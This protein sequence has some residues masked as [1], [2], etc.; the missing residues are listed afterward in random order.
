MKL[1]RKQLL[2]AAILCLTLRAPTPAAEGVKPRALE[3]WVRTELYFATSRAA[4]EVTA[5]D[6]AGFV[7]HHVT[8]LF[9]DGMTVLSG[10]GQFRKASGQL[11]KERSYLLIL[12][13]PAQLKDAN[14]RIQEL[15]SIYKDTF[16]QE[17]VLR[18]DSFALVSF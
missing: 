15:R 11:V 10:Y 2:V 14:S 8:R 16:G 13:Y 6:F 7:D 9:P 18:V 5:A 3:V 12:L 17:S 4:G 1:L